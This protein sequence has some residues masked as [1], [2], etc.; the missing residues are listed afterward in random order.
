MKRI[1]ISHASQDSDVA[2]RLCGD[3]RNVGHDVQ[4]DTEELRLGD[5]IIDFINNAINGSDTVFIIY[6]SNT[7]TAVW[8]KQEINAALWSDISQ[9]G[10]EVIVLTFGEVKLLPL[11]GSRLYG[12]LD[13]DQYQ[14]TLQKLCHKITEQHGVKVSPAEVEPN[15][16]NPFRRV[17]A[18]YFDDK[19]PRLLAESFSPPD[20]AKIQVLGAS[21]KNL[22]RADL[23]GR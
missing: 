23:Q 2:T 19:D 13:D 15:S 14:E 10:G 9:G 8:Q 6:S 22:K 3:L 17:R 5:D 18:E 1:F 21:C 16:P 20:A 7:P 11:L 4:I 12:R